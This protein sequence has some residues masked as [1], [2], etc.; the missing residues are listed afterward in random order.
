MLDEMDGKQAR[1]TGN[2]SPLGMMFDHGC[3]AFSVGFILTIT[4]KLLNMGDTMLTL[5]FIAGS[6]AVFHFA[7]LEEYYVGGLWLGPFNCITDLC[8]P[9]IGL[10]FYCG[11]FG[12]DWLN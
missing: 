2:S 9:L 6:N 7:T 4:A 12:N 5:T 8:F 10:Y 3:D 1:R 11:A